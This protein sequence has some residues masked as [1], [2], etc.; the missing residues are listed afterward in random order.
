LKYL[1]TASMDVVK[2]TYEQ[3]QQRC[4]TLE[5]AALEVVQAADGPLLNTEVLIAVKN[6]IDHLAQTLH[7]QVE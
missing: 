1:R 4:R 5:A 2:P 7:C 6:A 3:I